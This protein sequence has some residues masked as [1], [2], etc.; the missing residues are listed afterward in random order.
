MNRVL[1]FLLFADGFSILAVGM[2][3]PIYAIFVERIGGDILT[4]GGAYAAFSITAGILLFLI[5][6]WEDHVKHKEK[7]VV[8]GYALGSIGILGYLFISAPIH[9]FVVQIILG[10]AGAIGSPAYDAIYSRCLDRG[11]FA[12][13]WGM[14]E[15]MEYIVTAIAAL[16]GAFVAAFFGF[17]S[18]FLIMFFLSLVGLFISLRLFYITKSARPDLG[19]SNKVGRRKVAR[20]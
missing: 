13:E 7:L 3:G 9:L 5:S 6:R 11:R 15:S 2:F 8:L 14:Y 1:K 18:L 16:F 12:S 19:Q 20:A 10:M 17:Q 4:A